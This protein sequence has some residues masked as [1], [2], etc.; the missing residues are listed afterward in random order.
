M[1]S[2][3]RHHP[4]H[5]K[6]RIHDPHQPN[7]QWV[8]KEAL[9]VA[10]G[11]ILAP[12]RPPSNFPPNSRSTS[13]TASPYYSFPTSGAHTPGTGTPANAGLGGIPHGE[14]LHPHHAFLQA[15]HHSNHPHSTHPHTP[16]RLSHSVCPFS[17]LITISHDH[18]M[19]SMS[20]QQ[21]HHSPQG[22]SSRASPTGTKRPVE[23][24]LPEHAAQQ[25]QQQQQHLQIPVV[26]P[27]H[28]N[29]NAAPQG[30]A[31]ARS[32]AV[33][34]NGHGNV[35]QPRPIVTPLQ[36][37]CGGNARSSSLPAD[38]PD[39]NGRGLPGEPPSPPHTGGRGTPRAKF[40][41]KLQSKSAWDAL[42]HGSFS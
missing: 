25:Q 8:H 17:F 2:E 22:G 32:N 35:A 6:V 14:Y 4:H 7:P 36:P 9:R 16:S 12:K 21:S 34:A 37:M 30:G 29:E 41:E 33:V 1:P 39:A 10:I 40:I 5:D 24:G 11:S 3:Q 15:G 18:T 28:H 27:T 26:R 13:G 38:V 19:R 31:A 20:F 42:I 23:I